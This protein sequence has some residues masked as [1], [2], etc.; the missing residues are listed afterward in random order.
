[1]I[2]QIYE[3][4]LACGQ[5]VVIDTKK[6][7]KGAMFVAVGRLDARGCARG[8][9]W[10]RAA[11]E[12][13]GAGAAIISDRDLWEKVK[14]DP[15]FIFVEDSEK[16]LQELAAFHRQQ[17]KKESKGVLIA[18]GG[19]NG[20]TTTK[21]LIYSVL[22]KKYNVFATL[23]NLNNHLGVPLSL[24]S[25]RAAHQVAIIEIGAN[26]LGETAHLA[27]LAAPDFGLLT[28]CGKDHV[29]EYGS[30]ENVIIGNAELY[31]YI[32]KHKRV[33]FVSTDD[34]LLLQLSQNIEN[35]YFYGTGQPVGATV[36]AAPLLALDLSINADAQTVQTKLFGRFWR[37]TV[38]AAA[39]IGC[40]FG[41]DNQAIIAAIENYTPAAL[42]SQQL[43]WQG[44]HVWL[45]CYNA[46]PSSVAAF[47]EAVEDDKKHDFQ[48]LILGEMLELGAY[49]A[50]EHV[51]ILAHLA[52]ARPQLRAIFLVGAAFQNLDLPTGLAH[53]C[54][55]FLTAAAVAGY[56]AENP[57]PQNTQIYVKGSR[58]NQLET[59]FGIALH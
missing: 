13:F 32:A 3:S 33:G 23:G 4:Y 40:Y 20:K 45:D 41:V 12:Q 19:S 35:R 48:A 59:I 24:L 9:Q 54:H 2:K 30:F 42:R 36:A 56:L 58:G 18:I 34:A 10:A 22:S 21:E 51:E 25:L 57:L 44:Y 15:R 29:G 5:I 43:I 26:H 47:L 46:N 38:V 50:A 7:T 28:N 11:V 6:I 55:L 16:T 27:A 52:A 37:D 17:W 1:M 39:A 53:R 14:A 49:E 31:D 8:N